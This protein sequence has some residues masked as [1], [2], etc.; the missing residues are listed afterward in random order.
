MRDLLFAMMA[1]VI[2]LGTVIYA[3]AGWVS[4]IVG[5]VLLAIVAVAASRA[6]LR[7]AWGVL[8]AVIILGSFGA[9]TP[10][11]AAIDSMSGWQTLIAIITSFVV[12]GIVSRI[13]VV[14]EALRRARDLTF[15][16]G[17]GRN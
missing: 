12:S 11:D 9:I 7:R 3:P 6:A 16:A 14:A 8:S 1:F 4:L 5:L 17:S 2:G 13:P 10:I 15:R